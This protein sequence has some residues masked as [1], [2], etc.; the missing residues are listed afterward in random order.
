MVTCLPSKQKIGVRFPVYASFD[1]LML[2]QSAV[3]RPVWVKFPFK[4]L[5]SSSSGKIPKHKFMGDLSSILRED[6]SFI[7]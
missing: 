5:S 4:G 3:T 7:V 6:A 1:R 2:G